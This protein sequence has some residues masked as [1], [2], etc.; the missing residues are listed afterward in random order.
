METNQLLNQFSEQQQLATEEKNSKKNKLLKIFIYLFVFIFLISLGVF[1]FLAY[2]KRS[3]ERLLQQPN[4]TKTSPVVTI[5]PPPSI[6]P[7]IVLEST[8]PNNWKTYTNEKYGFVISYPSE[9][10]ADKGNILAL[11]GEEILDD[12]SIWFIEE[13]KKDESNNEGYFDG[14]KVNVQVTTNKQNRTAKEIADSFMNFAKEGVNEIGGD[15]NKC[16]INQIQIGNKE[17]YL[18]KPCVGAYTEGAESYIFSDKEKVILVS[19][20]IPNI[21]YLNTVKSILSTFKFLE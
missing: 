8:I 4:F 20:Y 13:G 14:Y 3:G 19:S 2:Q 6:T 18:F 7:T 9:A 5:M 11:S 15:I 16:S 21:K 17:G 12:I 10:N 1:G